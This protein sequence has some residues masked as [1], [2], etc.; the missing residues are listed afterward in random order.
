MCP[1][2]DMRHPHEIGKEFN[3]AF[4]TRKVHPE[5][6]S[7]QFDECLVKISQEGGSLEMNYQET[8][9]ASKFQLIQAR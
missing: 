1:K 7:F 2:P 8:E 6:L 4:G 3:G 5:I 9:A